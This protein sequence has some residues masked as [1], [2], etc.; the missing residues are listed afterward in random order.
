MLEQCF[1]GVLSQLQTEIDILNDIVPHHGERGT[2]NEESL[3]RMLENFLPSRYALG[4]GFVIDSFG[5]RS[6]QVDLLVYDDWTYSRLFKA[7][8]HLMFPVETVFAC[9]EV[10]TSTSKRDLAEVASENKTISVLKHY[11]QTVR[12]QKI[13]AEGNFGVAFSERHTRPPITVLVSHRCETDNPL[14][15]KKWFHES[16]GRDHLPDV[17]LFLDLG[18]IVV[19]T[20]EGFDCLLF[21]LRDI[22]TGGP[23]TNPLYAAQPLARA[24]V[25]GRTYQA[26]RWK[27]KDGGFP[28]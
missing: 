18:T 16:E 8:S 20:T 6:R 24:P 1:A 19:R 17:S 10:K 12:S 13:A 5:N 27:G 3:R 28:F 9:I 14:T 26:S 15:V 7:V 23:T 2:L 4:R 25:N 11:V 21:A 22:D